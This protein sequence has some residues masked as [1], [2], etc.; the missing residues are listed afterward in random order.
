[1]EG[2]ALPSDPPFRK[3]RGHVEAELAN[4]GPPGGIAAAMAA[5]QKGDDA[6]ALAI[7]EARLAADPNDVNALQ[8]VGLVRARRREDGAAL[9][10]FLKADRLAP[11]RPEILN[12]I[13]LLLKNRGDAEGARAA[14]E[15]AA[16]LAPAFADPHYNLA[17]LLVSLNEADAARA[18]FERAV[19]INPR[20]AE[21][22]GRYSRFLEERHEVELARQTAE[23]AL[24]IDPLHPLA[25]LTTANLDARAQNHQAVIDRLQP[26]LQR[27]SFGPVNDALLYGALSRGFERLGRFAESFE[28]CATANRLLKEHYAPTFAAA[29]GPRT[30][31]TLARLERFAAGA[32][33]GRWT[34]FDDLDGADPAFLV[35]FP[36]SGT[37]LLDQILSS[38]DEITVLEEKE[39]VV[40]AWTDLI[41]RADGLDRWAGLSK[42]EIEGYRAAYWRRVEAQAPNRR[43]TFIDKLPLD[44]ALLGLIHRIFPR[45]KIIFALRDPRDVVLSCF[46]Q[47]FGMN[48]AMYQFL[49]LETAARYYD[50]VMRLGELWRAK[51]PL[52]LYVVRYEKVVADLRAEIA[53]LLE[54]LGLR[55]NDALLG[56]RRTARAKI[57]RTPS[58]KQV[59]E[60]IYDFSV[61]KWRNYRD[62]LA[63][64]RPLLEPWAQKLGYP[65]WPSE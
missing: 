20:H 43:S 8:I 7:A 6:S 10:A 32:D 34:R 29:E 35:G 30:P 47:T 59:I 36:R 39:N 37:T 27:K 28:A 2:F 33:L 46:Q 40:D 51:L 11:N 64:I 31:Q 18:A 54:F 62:R 65:A 21:A 55:W 9:E 1:L 16:R 19:A 56:Y 38:H 15:K 22:L 49:D 52:D 23:R 48:A 44:T 41:L 60:P 63:P 42:S 17:S 53:P 50:Q 58:A 24:A 45:A 14:F 4:S 57:I 13:G 3:T 26:A 25:L 12:S 5:V 61:G